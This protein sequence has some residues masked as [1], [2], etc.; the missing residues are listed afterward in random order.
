MPTLRLPPIAKRAILALV[1]FP[2]SLVLVPAAGWWAKH[3]GA[4]EALAEASEEQ[5]QEVPSVWRDE[6]TP[7]ACTQAPIPWDY[8]PFCQHLR[9]GAL[10]RQCVYTEDLSWLCHDSPKLEGY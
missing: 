8:R 1:L 2:W 4:S 6:M 9:R 5:G 7:F 3:L 10:L